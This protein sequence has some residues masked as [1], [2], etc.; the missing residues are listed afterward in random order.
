MIKEFKTAVVISDHLFPLVD[1][2]LA[3]FSQLKL[4]T[5]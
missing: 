4:L 1:V 5:S 3:S 2:C